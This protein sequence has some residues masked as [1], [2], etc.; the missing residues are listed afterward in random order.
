[1]ALYQPLDASCKEIRLLKIT[2]ES[3]GMI[4]CRLHTVSL[5]DGI[6]RFTALSYVWGS[7]TPNTSILVNGAEL[8]ITMNLADALKSVTS[9][10]QASFPGSDPADFWLWVDSV[11]INQAD[12]QERGSQVQLMSTL[13]QSAELVIGWVGA[14]EPE[15]ILLA[16]DTILI[17]GK[18]FNRLAWKNSGGSMAASD[19]NWLKGY[20]Y[21]Y[22]LDSEGANERW[23][24]I[25]HLLDLPYWTRLWIFQEA[26]L[27]RKLL[28]SSPFASI[29]FNILA[30]TT[31][32]VCQM[33]TVPQG[34][35]TTPV[36]ELWMALRL[37]TT[38]W[39]RVICIQAARS[40]Y[41][42]E[43]GPREAFRRSPKYLAHRLALGSNLLEATDPR[44]YVYGMLGLNG[45]HIM[46][47]Y[48]SEH[49]YS[50][51]MDY[52]K[53][54]TSIP[55]GCLDELG[56]DSICQLA[57]LDFSGIGFFEY[58]LGCPSW[59][60]NF[61][62]RARMMVPRNGVTRNPILTG[63]DDALE[64]LGNIMKVKGLV[65]GRI[66]RIA[67]SDIPPNG[68]N[69]PRE[70][71]VAGSILQYLGG[72]VARYPK[73]VTG[74]SPIHALTRILLGEDDVVVSP[75]TAE[76]F[77]R[78]F[79][80]LLSLCGFVFASSSDSSVATIEDAARLKLG[81]GPEAN[82]IRWLVDNFWT[83]SE[84]HETGIS[85]LE[86]LRSAELYLQSFT[87]DFAERFVQ[88]HKL[89]Q[90]SIILETEDGHVG[91]CPRGSQ[92]G[93]ILVALYGNKYPVVLRPA[94]EGKYRFVGNAS[95]WGF[96][97][98]EAFLPPFSAKRER[99]VPPSARKQR[100]SSSIGRKGPNKPNRGVIPVSDL[101]TFEVI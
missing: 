25:Y 39:K 70:F 65:I 38:H 34:Q 35:L 14:A 26:V 31:L 93:D 80:L 43:S 55:G 40:G 99:N 100:K 8:S 72:L 3:Q 82:P 33:L 2:G 69:T 66:H 22:T 67:L 6:P 13:Y 64:I 75:T 7:P 94:E 28:L 53:C 23:S 54:W 37:N 95:V 21:L 29:D 68:A 50:A 42:P 101:Q 90:D 81:L 61:P 27:A 96:M 84:I 1:M 91:A 45:L 9:H 76:L 59:V 4:T 46:P 48:K 63:K 15:R 30:H 74:I 97:D 58:P 71:E 77:R 85:K 89:F 47:N 24:A 11:C 83:T 92:V 16:F 41:T 57:F 12:L 79:E 5:A 87:N 73:Y 10:W 56:A 49:P 17:L 20:P 52:V 60:P 18:E 62:A 36:S 44:D 88:I 32:G 19:L 86:T 98:G 78:G 51:W